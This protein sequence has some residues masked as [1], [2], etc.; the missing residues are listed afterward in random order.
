MTVKR[1]TVVEHVEDAENCEWINMILFKC[2]KGWD[3]IAGC[4]ITY[5]IEYV[6]EPPWQQLIQRFQQQLQQQLR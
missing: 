6:K 3:I 4:S 1:I 2:E 5:L